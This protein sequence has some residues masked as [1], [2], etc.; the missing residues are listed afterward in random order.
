[1]FIFFPDL[2]NYKNSERGLYIDINNDTP[3]AVATNFEELIDNIKIFDN[4]KYINGINEFLKNIGF[5]EEK[6]ASEKV[7]K[8][9]LEDMKN[10]EKDSRKI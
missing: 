10:N 6:N 2:Q 5:I 1:M 8:F 7:A 3:F 4:N 9:I